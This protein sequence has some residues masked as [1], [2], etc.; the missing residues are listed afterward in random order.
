[1]NVFQFFLLCVALPTFSDAAY[2]ILSVPK[3]SEGKLTLY[4]GEAAQ[5]MLPVRFV[6]NSY[7]VVRESGKATCIH[8]DMIEIF[9]LIKDFCVTA[10]GEGKDEVNNILK[11]FVPAEADKEDYFVWKLEGTSNGDDTSFTVGYKYDKDS[12]A[13]GDTLSEE[14]ELAPLIDAE[15]AADV[16]FIRIVEGRLSVDIL[17]REALVRASLSALSSKKSGSAVAFLQWMD[18]TT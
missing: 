12:R 8:A 2:V 7:G 15:T 16:H 5:D 17:Q 18:D 13:S 14:A 10:S 6:P 3:G 4:P 11:D 9:Q 1:M